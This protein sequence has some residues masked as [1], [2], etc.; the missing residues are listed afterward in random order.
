VHARRSQVPEDG[1]QRK[2]WA[3][4]AAR[5]SVHAIGWQCP[6]A[7]HS[8]PGPQLVGVQGATQLVPAQIWPLRH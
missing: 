3:Q 1:L 8:W 4:M 2:F 7:R 6:S 5:V